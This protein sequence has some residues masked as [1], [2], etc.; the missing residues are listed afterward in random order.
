MH[1]YGMMARLQADWSPKGLQEAVKG[2]DVKCIDCNETK[3]T[4]KS[5]P[6]AEFF[7]MLTKSSAEGTERVYKLKARASDTT[8]WRIESDRGG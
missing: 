5:M 8:R 2:S 1:M 7:E 3:E 4:M 6:A